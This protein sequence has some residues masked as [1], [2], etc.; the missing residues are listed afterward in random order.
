MVSIFTTLASGWGRLAVTT[1]VSILRTSW[2]PAMRSSCCSESSPSRLGVFFVS[3]FDMA[4]PTGNLPANDITTSGGALCGIFGIRN[5]ESAVG[6]PGFDR[7]G[8]QWTMAFDPR[9][10]IKEM[11]RGVHASRNLTREQAHELFTAIF[12][13]EVS[14]VALG[15]ILVALRMKGETVEELAGMMDALAGHV[16]AVRL[17][18]RRM[19][20]LVIP[21]YNGARKLPNLVPLLA[22]LVAREGVPVLLHGTT[23]E[24]HRVGT[25]EIL[26]LLDHPPAASIDEAEE[27]LEARLLA[28]V[29]IDILAPDLARLIDVRLAMGVRN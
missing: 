6:I 18:A 28:P 22:L 27:R 20:T 4:P 13:A 15:A 10:Y 11:A 21:T 25:F 9:P 26:A 29:P 24:P 3:F 14:D 16:L 12:A 1:M 17:P 5:A 23:Q 2:P 7:N 19:A 8:R